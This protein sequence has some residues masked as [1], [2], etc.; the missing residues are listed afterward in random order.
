MG[1]LTQ[2]PFTFDRVIRLGLGIAITYGLL[3]TL[4]YLQNV[5]IPFAIASLLAYLINPF[6]SF[7][8]KKAK[9][10][11]RIASVLIALVLLTAL[12]VGIGFITI[13]AIAGEFSALQDTL[14]HLTQKSDVSEQAVSYLPAEIWQSLMQLF[15]KEEVKKLIQNES[16]N[17]WAYSTAQKLIPGVWGIFSGV[18]S[19]LISIIGLS[20]IVLYIIFILVDYNELQQE[21]K[22]LIPPDYKDELFGFLHDFSQA[23]SKYFRAQSLIALI[24]GILFAIGFSI[25]GLPLG[26]LLGL[27]VGFLN[28]VP[29]L[30]TLGIIPASLLALVHSLESGNSFWTTIAFVLLVFVVVQTIQETILNPKILSDAMGLNPAVMLLSLSIWGKILGILG[31]I[32]ALPVTFLI[33]SYYKHFLKKKSKIDVIS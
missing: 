12:F 11:N 23:M 2:K 5:L 18:I 28:L 9:V 27:F 6:V 31:L 20:V 24:V 25:I 26:I 29:Y 33:L 19:V 1:F 8:Q 4:N 7:I 16:F 3:L 17:D 15:E 22:S 14:L 13:P 21:W 32:I 30:Q 10:K